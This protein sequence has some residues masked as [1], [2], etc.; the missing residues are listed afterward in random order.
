MGG[1]LW[2]TSQFGRGSQFFFT[3]TC[4]IGEWNLDQ[5]RQKTL[6]PHP[7]RRILFIDTLHHDP[8]VRE[9]V[10]Q[11]GLEITVVD[12]MEEACL[13][14]QA[15]SG[16]FDTVLVDQLSVVE[17]LRDVEH[18]RYIPLVLITPQIP[19]LNLKYCLDF[20]CVFP[21][22]CSA[23]SSVTDR[24]WGCRIANCVESPTNAQDMCNAL[25]PALEASNR[26]PSE[27]GADASF[28][29][30][31]AEDSAYFPS[32]SFESITDVLSPPQIS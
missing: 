12:T 8:S 30:L 24:V 22:L 23:A 29:V 2:V 28:K 19:Q 1:E 3:I 13:L 18:L 31:L 20:G 16:Y 11:L 5:V 21:S 6:I 4:R 9:S 25:L 17:R 7:G 27:R 10:E 26:I 15:Q 32:S 14:D